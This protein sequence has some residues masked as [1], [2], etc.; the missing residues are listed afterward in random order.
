MSWAYLNEFSPKA[1]VNGVMRIADMTAVKNDLVAMTSLFV[2]SIGPLI[3]TLTN[4]PS[5]AQ[6]KEVNPPRIIPMIMFVVICFDSMT[7]GS[8]TNSA[9]DAIVKKTPNQTFQG[10]FSFKMKLSIVIDIAG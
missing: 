7:A 5:T 4:T 9:E 6:K 1:Q 10:S 8:K 2:N 3:P